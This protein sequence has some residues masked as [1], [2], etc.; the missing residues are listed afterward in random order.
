M[1]GWVGSSNLQSAVSG[2]NRAL[3]GEALKRSLSS[4]CWK[5][6]IMLY[7]QSVDADGMGECNGDGSKCP[8]DSE[9]LCQGPRVGGSITLSFRISAWEMPFFGPACIMTVISAP[10][11]GKVKTHMHTSSCYF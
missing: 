10:D 8:T 4:S 2:V 7:V 1:S 5:K 6:R 11:S 3:Q 9:G